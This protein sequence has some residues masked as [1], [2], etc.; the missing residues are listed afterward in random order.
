M[1]SG[2]V[3][4][5]CNVWQTAMLPALFP[6]LRIRFTGHVDGFDG[7]VFDS[8]AL[9]GARRPVKKAWSALL[10]AVTSSAGQLSYRSSLGPRA[11]LLFALTGLRGDRVQHR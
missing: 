1:F 10:F 7:P 9:R 2:H 6:L 11:A 5:A 8:S 4:V 3:D